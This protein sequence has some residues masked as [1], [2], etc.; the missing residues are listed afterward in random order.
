VEPL[1]EELCRR[2]AVGREGPTG[3]EPEEEE[4]GKLAV[5]REL[6]GR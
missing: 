2:G 5:R 4:V 6:G 1:T 3:A